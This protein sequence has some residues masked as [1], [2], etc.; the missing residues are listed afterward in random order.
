MI[1]CVTSEMIKL[2]NRIAYVMLF[3]SS[4]LLFACALGFEPRTRMSN[5][6]L[7]TKFVFCVYIMLNMISH[8]AVSHVCVCV[9]V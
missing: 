3:I 9:C 5:E 8:I 2:L 4:S 1:T 6:L 7:F